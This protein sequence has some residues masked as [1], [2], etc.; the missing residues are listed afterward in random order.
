MSTRRVARVSER[1]QQDVSELIQRE[2][3]DPRLGFVTVTGVE[4]SPDLKHARVHV[5]VLGSDEE[6]RESMKVLQRASGFL[7]RELGDRLELR[8]IPDLEFQLDRSTRRGVRI[9]QVLNELAR[10]Q[11]EGLPAPT[12]DTE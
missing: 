12:D 7:R 4:V 5:S 9:G 2:I 8:Y 11:T 1:I 3:N 10:E 6:E